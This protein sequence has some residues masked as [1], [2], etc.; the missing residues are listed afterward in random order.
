MF[1]FTAP[2]DL[3]DED[4]SLIGDGELSSTGSSKKGPG[5]MLSGGTGGSG[6]IGGKKAADRKSARARTV[7]SEKQLN[8]L[9]VSTH[10]ISIDS[11]FIQYNDCIIYRVCRLKIVI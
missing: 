4:M 7:L 9:K 10:S 1:H 5:G 6:G 8:I 11:C 2:C 3:S